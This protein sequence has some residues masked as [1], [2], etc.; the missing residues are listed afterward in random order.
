MPELA[1]DWQ[2]WLADNLLSGVDPSELVE[3]LAKRG[4]RDAKAQVDAALA[5][6]YLRSALPIAETL[7]RRESLL[8]I[9]ASLASLGHTTIRRAPALANDAFLVE[10]Y[11]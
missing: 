1:D 5:H 6:P 7:R 9:Q 4:V 3:Q 2:R 10:H 8:A 11:A